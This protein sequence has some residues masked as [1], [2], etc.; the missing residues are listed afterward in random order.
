[1]TPPPHLPTRAI[2]RLQDPIRRLAAIVPAVDRPHLPHVGVFAELAPALVSDS[3]TLTTLRAGVPL[4]HEAHYATVPQVGQCGGLPSIHGVEGAL[5][6]NR[7][8]SLR[9]VTDT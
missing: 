7:Y 5:R 2:V 4:F 1:M 8:R 3:L 6:R 9:I